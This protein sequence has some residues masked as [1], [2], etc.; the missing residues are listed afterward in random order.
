MID[1]LTEDRT[2]PIIVQSFL[3][4]WG[5]VSR[6]E[7]R[8]TR[9]HMENFEKETFFTKMMFCVNNNILTVAGV[10]KLLGVTDMFVKGRARGDHKQAEQDQGIVKKSGEFEESELLHKDW[11]D[12]KLVA[13]D[14]R[15]YSS[16]QDEV[17]MRNMG[18]WIIFLQFSQ[19]EIKGRK[20]K[21][22]P[23]K[24]GKQEVAEFLHFQELSDSWQD[25]VH[26]DTCLASI[27]AHLPGLRVDT[28][29]QLM[30][31]NPPTITMKDVRIFLKLKKLSPHSPFDSTWKSFVEYCRKF[32]N[33]NDPFKAKPEL[34]KDF[35][36][37]KFQGKE[38]R[39]E[40]VEPQVKSRPLCIVEKE[41]FFRP[42]YKFYSDN[43]YRILG[44]LDWHLE[45]SWVSGP[46]RECREIEILTRAVV[47]CDERLRP[48]PDDP[49]LSDAVLK[50]TPNYSYT[51]VRSKH[52]EE[53]F[54][55]R[56]FTANVLEDVKS[57]ALPVPVAA[58]GL[59]VTAEMVWAAL[60]LDSF[61][62]DE[63]YFDNENPGEQE[64][65]SVKDYVYLGYGSR[66]Q[67]WKEDSTVSL[68][69]EV[70]NR[71]VSVEKVAAQ[72][73]VSR[74]DILERCGGVKEQAE[75][76]A[77]MKLLEIEKMKQKAEK[78]LNILRKKSPLQLQ[79]EMAENNMERLSQYERM[80][81]QNMRERQALL[82]SLDFNKE[83]NEL[84]A[85]T[86]K[87][88]PRQVEAVQLRE[89]SARVKRRSEVQQLKKLKTDHDCSSNY[90]WSMLQ[91]QRAS[92]KWF[93][94]WVPRFNKDVKL[95]IRRLNVTDRDI[96][97]FYDEEAISSS[98]HIPK[99]E[100]SAQDLL[101][102]TPA[103]HR[104]KTRLDS[105]SADL[106]QV[107]PE[108][109]LVS[110]PDW[111]RFQ[112]VQE[113]L[114]S[115][116]ELTSLDTFQDYVCF[117]T[118][119]G[120]VGVSLAGRAITIKP[121]NRKVTRTL[122]LGNKN[123]NGPG[124]LSAGLDGTVR[125]TDMVRQ[126]VCLEYSWD[127]S[128]MGKQGVNW[129][130]E[131][132]PYSFLLDCGGEINHIDIRAKEASQLIQLNNEQAQT[133]ILTNLS[134]HP[135]N[136]NLLSLCRGNSVQI[137]DLRKASSAVV[138][139]AGAGDS[140]MAGGGWS[141]KG[142]YLATCAQGGDGV[143]EIVVYNG[144]DFS[145]PLST[146]TNPKMTS[147]FPFTGV[148]WCPWEE[149]L[150]L[151]AMKKA[152]QTEL[153]LKPKHTVVAV[154]C[155]SGRVVGEL[156]VSLDDANFMVHCSKSREMVVVGNSKGQGGMAIFKTNKK[157]M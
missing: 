58:S 40:E 121:H 145:Q 27:S 36:M 42:A 9:G 126:I 156:S 70:R 43:L 33:N 19:M 75:K 85:L 112:L 52:S 114:V 98:N 31:T 101:E 47:C 62:Q 4:K 90:E 130:E 92:P 53:L 61:A 154:D 87:S 3:D 89:K 116:S 117:G 102:I 91:E 96:N 128:Y 134:L 69:E 143:D 150:F 30:S 88:K 71:N 123:H 97:D 84:R 105:F 56:Q 24:A 64:S 131:R 155:T 11:L 146:F 37:S 110:R 28:V 10:A 147:F 107:R 100:L 76:E 66:G 93:G 135:S 111:D 79:I 17:K 153:E 50:F 63:E 41:P 148:T 68:L 12:L 16:S 35:L 20:H 7:Y 38:M 54:W 22:N 65:I 133:N 46:L 139:L 49:D 122:F 18:Q 140:M 8:K 60:K 157:V 119:S 5:V 23:Y 39:L 127:Q 95:T 151:T 78:E 57:K 32:G 80:R 138:T 137:W 152:K 77:D 6:K 1:T 108:G 120:G 44:E 74:K 34:V 25:G 136:K 59:G 67:F 72:L 99:F 14:Q 118:Q 2:I 129:L 45:Y 13:V 125:M 21:C 124:V 48:D 86:P 106:K 55:G 104:S 141:K 144:L 26:P 94:H 73:G 81:L 82:E 109:P 132:G 29:E 103:Y 15:R 83:K 149:N 142:S 113:S 115:S 51:K